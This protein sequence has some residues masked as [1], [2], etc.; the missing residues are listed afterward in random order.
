MPPPA[1]RPRSR[2][3]S[4]DD[5]GLRTASSIDRASQPLL[6]APVR[7]ERPNAP[8]WTPEGFYEATRGAEDVRDKFFLIPHDFD[9][10]R[11]CL[12]IAL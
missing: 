5:A 11:R 4:P 10:G 2:A 8:V 7:A 9:T 3:P 12:G 6:R 1:A